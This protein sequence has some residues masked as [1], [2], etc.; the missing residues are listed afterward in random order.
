MLRLRVQAFHLP[1]EGNRLEEYEDAWACDAAVGRLAVADGASDA[2]ES[3]LWARTLVQSFVREPP[4]PE[5][6]MRWLE[7]RIAEWK[8]GIDWARLPWYAAEK[9]RRGAF[10]TLL[11]VA[12]GQS[13][14]DVT[15]KASSCGH[16]WA[17]AVG[18]ACLFQVRD[19]EVIVRF[20][21]QQAADF[22]TTPPLLSTQPD[23]NLRSLEALRVCMGECRPGDLFILAT[24]ALA[25]WFLGELE[26]GNHPWGRWKELT[27]QQFHW[28]VR[29]LRR[30]GKMRNDDVT[31]LL[32][33]TE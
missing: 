26:A 20:P 30:R 24:D 11:G 15:E 32:G 4:S 33:W 19:N 18:D 29:T 1:K 7:S 2:F 21:L 3:R 31:L 12:F 23:Y 28:L 17:L 10:A 6:L 16:W 14:R 5:E 9:A 25:A 13:L 22:S 27:S 8:A